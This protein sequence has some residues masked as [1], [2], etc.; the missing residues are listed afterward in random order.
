[1][2]SFT[3]LKKTFRFANLL[4]LALLLAAFLTPVGRA[5]DQARSARDRQR[6]A[7]AEGVRN[8]DASAVAKIFTSDAKLMLPGFETITG[9]E[10][11]QKFWQA[12]LGSRM[13]QGI[14][15]ASID[16]TGDEQGL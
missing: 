15:F 2:K 9:R 13:V 16:I 11:I 7:L 3:L 14:S 8:R 6:Q 10:A 12:G 1:M 4:S 5:E